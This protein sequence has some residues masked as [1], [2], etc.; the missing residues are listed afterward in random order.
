MRGCDRMGAFYNSRNGLRDIA[1][2]SDYKTLYWNKSSE[3]DTDK[4]DQVYWY[5]AFVE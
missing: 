3:E 5:L 1:W 2:S 4:L